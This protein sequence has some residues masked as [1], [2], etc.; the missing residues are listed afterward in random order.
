MHGADPKTIEG[1]GSAAYAEVVLLLSS[2]H[3]IQIFGRLHWIL[4]EKRRVV[5]SLRRI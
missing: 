4:P 5:Q 3:V 2:K 1:R